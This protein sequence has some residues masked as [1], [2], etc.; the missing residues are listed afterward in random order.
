MRK[1]SIVVLSLLVLLLTSCGKEKVDT[2]TYAVFPYLPDAGYY[3]ELIEQR[4]AETEPD[5]K[6]VRAEWDCYTD[7]LPDDVDVLM[8]DAVMRDTLI[9]KG[10]IRPIEPNC[11]SDKDDIYAFA[12]DGL[13]VDGKLYG[14]PV[15]MC[16]NFLIYDTE[17]TN[18]ADAKHL[19][20]IEGA[21]ILVINSDLPLNRTQYTCE[22]LADTLGDPDPK[23]AADEDVMMADI[24]RLAVD[25]H[26]R[27]EDAQV[28]SAYDSGV[29]KGYIGF[30]ESM[31]L[32][33]SR[34]NHTNIKSISFSDK[35]DIPRLYVDAVAINSKVG[36]GQRYDK[37]LELMNI[38]AD[39]DVLT[40][41][42]V[43]NGKPQYL[44]IAR[45]S[46][47]MVLADRFP[48]YSRLDD[49]ASNENNNVITG[50]HP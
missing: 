19:T 28:V 7:E 8:Y 30:S 34:S 43:Q 2:L 48:L 31:R 6:L 35:D 22:V 11:I 21:G 24:D 46:P 36:D 49:L 4:W 41:L 45:K 25:V 42:S 16:G 18:I 12:L 37:C 33:D 20:D 26:K 44:L 38:I 47:Y 14:I 9:E 1:S 29:G 27:D 17:C 10:S 40:E 23:A 3:Q 32:L 50:P 15:F 5:I 39:A 13:T